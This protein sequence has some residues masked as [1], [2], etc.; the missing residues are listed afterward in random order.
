M[1]MIHRAERFS[2]MLVE[3]TAADA[4]AAP[5]PAHDTAPER[6]AAWH[7]PQSVEGPEDTCGRNHEHY[8]NIVSSR[9]YPAHAAQAAKA[10]RVAHVV[11][12][13]AMGCVLGEV[14]GDK[15]CSCFGLVLPHVCAVA[16][17]SETSDEQVRSRV[18]SSESAGRRAGRDEVHGLCADCPTSTGPSKPPK[19]VALGDHMSLADSESLEEC[20]EESCRAPLED[21]RNC[22]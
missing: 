3:G 18:D 11:L 22:I 6:I 2:L 21:C 17:S 8:D 20:H 14:D 1:S 15:P 10:L 12:G 16:P 19:M 5:R 9:A 7:V 13:I 4:A